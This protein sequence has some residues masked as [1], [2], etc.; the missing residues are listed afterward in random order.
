MLKVISGW[1]RLEEKVP[2]SWG[3]SPTER[4]DESRGA[5]S[6]RLRNAAV[7]CRRGDK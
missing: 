5:C 6:E 2:A 7:S 3:R 4:N 1:V